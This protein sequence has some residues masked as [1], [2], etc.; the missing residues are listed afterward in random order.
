M[1]NWGGPHHGGFHGGPL[2]H[3]GGPGFFGGGHPP[4]HGGGFFGPGGGHFNGGPGYGVSRGHMGPGGFVP[5]G[6]GFAPWLGALAIGAVAASA[7]APY[8]GRD[9]RGRDGTVVWRE[10]GQDVTATVNMLT[11]RDEG[12]KKSRR[13]SRKRDKRQRQTETDAQAE[14]ACA[15]PAPL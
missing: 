14:G 9:G 6:P 1:A 12:E 4:H 10:G 13:F 15:P 2:A 8:Q 7:V 3:G 5:A 11:V